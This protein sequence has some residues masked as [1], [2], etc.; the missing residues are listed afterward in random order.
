MLIPPYKGPAIND[1]VNIELGN[2][3]E[4]Q[5][6]NLAEDLGEQN[7]LAEANPDKLQEM[8]ATFESIRGKDAGKIEQLEL[9]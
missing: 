9:K 7:N 4:Y 1:R 8:I 3:Q 2:A 6:Y 5:L